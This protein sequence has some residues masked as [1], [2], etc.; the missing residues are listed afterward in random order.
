MCGIIPFPGKDPSRFLYL[1]LVYGFKIAW[2]IWMGHREEPR[3]PD[4]NEKDP[5]AGEGK[6]D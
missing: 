2:E 1:V 4:R 5:S 6:G 3:K